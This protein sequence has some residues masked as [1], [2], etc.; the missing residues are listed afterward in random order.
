MAVHCL[1][2][3]E[4]KVVAARNP[5]V[6]AVK[7]IK[8]VFKANA[9]GFKCYCIHFLLQK[10]HTVNMYIKKP[11]HHLTLKKT[12]GG[13]EGM[14]NALFLLIYCLVCSINLSVL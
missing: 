4:H 5:L 3:C 10:K 1:S 9:T 2:A 12:R 11:I 13:A 7:L 8:H 14:M 6:V